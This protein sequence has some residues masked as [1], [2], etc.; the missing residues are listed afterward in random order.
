MSQVLAVFGVA[1]IAWAVVGALLIARDLERRGISVSYLWLRIMIVKY[2]GQY[3]RAT[4]QETGRVGPLFYHYVVPIN[5]ALV[6]FVVL[7]VAGCSDDGGSPLFAGHT[8]TNEV[9]D[10]LAEDPDDWASCAGAGLDMPGPIPAGLRP[11]YPNP[12]NALITIPFTVPAP[13]HV[14]VAIYGA[15]TNSGAVGGAAQVEVLVRTLVD[16]Q[17]VAGLH[18]VS[19]NGTDSDGEPVPPGLYRCRMTIFDCTT[20]GDIRIV[21]CPYPAASL[22]E[23]DMLAYLDEHWSLEKLEAAFDP[24]YLSRGDA[25]PEYASIVGAGLE[26]MPNVGGG[27]TSLP[28]WVDREADLQRFVENVAMWNQFVFG[29]DDFRHPAAFMEPDEVTFES[30][31]DPR[32]SAYRRHF[33]GE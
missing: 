30:L 6:V 7:A 22:L 28:M 27:A 14:Q 16:G 17:L 29:W 3:A 1:C 25:N 15:G 32:V 4:K 31:S 13:Q 23:P 2:L 11:A 19:W 10:V 26:F 12:T 24:S 33:R 18:Q 20:H 9:G 21:T 8:Q 5:L